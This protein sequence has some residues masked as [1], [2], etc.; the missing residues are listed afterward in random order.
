MEV[1]DTFHS[2]DDGEKARCFSAVRSDA[3]G[4]KLTS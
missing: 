2:S 4:P 3:I 1:C